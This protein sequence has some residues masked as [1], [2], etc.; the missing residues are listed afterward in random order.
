MNAIIKPAKEGQLHGTVSAP[1]SK[2][3]THRAILLASLAKG[4]SII[5]NP[6]FSDDTIRTIKACQ[7][8]GVDIKR[9]GDILFIDGVNGEFP[10]KKSPIHIDC[11]ES[12]TTMRLILAVA[13]LSP[14]IIH[15]TGAERLRERPMEEL[16]TALKLFGVHMTNDSHLTMKGG[17]IR[18]GKLKISGEKSSQFINALLLIAPY[19][20]N[21]F[22]VKVT[23][24]S[25]SPYVD[26]TIDVM[27]VFGVQVEKEMNT[28]GIKSTQQYTAQKYTVEGDYSSASYF[29]ALKALMKSDI[30]VTNLNTNSIQGDKRF[31]EILKQMDEN[32]LHGMHI[33]LGNNPDLVPIVSILAA[34]A[35]GET[36]I[37]NIAHLKYKESDRLASVREN[38]TRMGIQV[39][40]TPDSLTIHGGTPKGSIIDTYNDHRIAMSFAVAGIH[41]SGET[42]IK[43]AEVVKKSYP[44][45]WDD[46]NTIGA[47]VEIL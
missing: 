24:L 30:A 22:E 35:R 2:S 28:Y 26:I 20:E 13:S 23:H 11:G 5:V 21:D 41:A 17:K 8:L 25:S 46:L 4:R 27:R 16:M 18:G 39:L 40:Q 29:L 19:A 14:T 38:L 10:H 3:Y 45:F 6:L 36:V 31:I 1:P 42:V 34:Y 9:R 43:N 15:I 44:N 7:Q 33:D 47:N 37:H 12:G 32:K